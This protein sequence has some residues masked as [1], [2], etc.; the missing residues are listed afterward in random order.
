MVKNFRE[1]MPISHRAKQ[2]A[3]FAALKGFEDAI[4]EKERIIEPQRE[5]SEEML[6]ELNYTFLKLEKGKKI[7][8]TYYCDGNYLDYTGTI[9]KIAF[10]E[11]ILFIDEI[12]IPFDDVSDIILLS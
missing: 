7:T 10:S 1:K 5:F 11:K 12:K 2:F 3:P 6:N 9:K 8:I 4:K